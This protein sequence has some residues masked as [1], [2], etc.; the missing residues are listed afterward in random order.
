MGSH[1]SSLSQ[2][3][4]DLTNDSDHR[5]T[6]TYPTIKK[7]LGELD[8]AMPSSGFACYEERLLNAGFSHV[9][10]VTDTPNV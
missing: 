10:W 4:T 3:I 8:K 7:F 9:H 5:N 2:Q 1:S 6:V